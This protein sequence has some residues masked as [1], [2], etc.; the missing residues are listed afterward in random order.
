MVDQK[1]VSVDQL[2]AAYL[3][4]IAC[5]SI[6]ESI[7]IHLTTFILQRNVVNCNNVHAGNIPSTSSKTESQTPEYL[8][9]TNII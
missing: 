9:E 7:T 6:C 4:I 2:I 5:D 1:N 3:P 8:T